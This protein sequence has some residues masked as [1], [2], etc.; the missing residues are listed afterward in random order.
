MPIISSE[1][2]EKFQILFKECMRGKSLIR[3]LHNI[4]LRKISPFRGNGIDYGAKNGSSSYYKF[5]DVKDARMTFT[6]YYSNN[7]EVLSIDFEKNFDLS[8]DPF[9]FALVFNTLEHIFNYQSFL[10]NINKS[11]KDGGRIEGSIPFLHPY[12]KDPDDYFRYTHTGL[13]KILKNANFENIKIAT[14]CTGSL[15][16]FASLTSRFLKIKL[17]IFFYWITLLTFDKILNH[18]NERNSMIYGCLAFS[19]TKK[20]D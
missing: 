9:D 11:L 10:I 12:H 18:F 8:K 1:K 19:A 3:T 17:L 16:V 4:Y 2:I 5:I 13:E 6:D 14:L 15:T 20:C 7:K